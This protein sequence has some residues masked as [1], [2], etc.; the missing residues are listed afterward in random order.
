MI[1]R[2]RQVFAVPL[3]MNAIFDQRTIADLALHIQPI[4]QQQSALNGD[5]ALGRR[6]S[7][8]ATDIEIPV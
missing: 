8:G 2:L 4:L 7:T 5:N 6:S 1:S 3:K